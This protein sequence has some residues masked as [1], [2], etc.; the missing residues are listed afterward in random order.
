MY[1]YLSHQS[2][3]ISLSATPKL[4]RH[5]VQTFNFTSSTDQMRNNLAGLSPSGGGDGP[6]A[7]TAA[8]HAVFSLGALEHA[9]LCILGVQPAKNPYFDKKYEISVVLAV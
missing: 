5:S 6:E 3:D 4:S 2:K 1:Q 9:Y 7:V 8:L